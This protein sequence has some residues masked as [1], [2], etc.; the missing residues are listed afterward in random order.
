MFK[1]HPI[2]SISIYVVA[3]L[4]LVYEMALQVSPSVMTESLMSAFAIGAGKLGI[5]AS[6]YYYSYAIMQVPAGLLHDRFGPRRLI[7]FSAILCA[8]G[9]FFF[10]STTA[11]APA[12]MGRFLMGVG[13][14]FAFIGVLVVT[15][16]WFDKRYFALLVGVGQFL[17]AVG[18]LGGELPLAYAVDHLG[19]RASMLLLALIG[20]VVALLAVFII[21][22]YPP[23][24]V[25]HHKQEDGLRLIVKIKE[26]L[27]HGQTYAI[28]AFA[29]CA[30]GPVLAI[31]ALWGVPYLMVLHG[32]ENTQAAFAISMLWVGVAISSPFWGWISDHLG[33]RNLPLQICSSIGLVASIFLIYVTT[34]PFWGTCVLLL[35]IGV[36]GAGQIVTFALV[37]ENNRP[38]MTGAAVG[39]NNMAVVAGGAL[40]QPL[41]GWLLYLFWNGATRAGIPTYTVG[42][43]QIALAIVPICFLVALLI[44]LFYIRETFCKS[45]F[46]HKRKA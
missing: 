34:V 43:Y 31:A 28:C 27:T 32:I 7:T 45:R 24:V 9:A 14:A 10:G 11:F 26:I 22:N 23:E 19:W 25:P 42:N 8:L 18:A 20:G 30:W 13:S 4:F 2:R 39:L 36:A 37:R 6:F 46:E 21:R 40:F 1:A 33:R 15:A 29:F 38:S 12:A 41:V 16:R 35:L 3:T 44:S 17:A 5:M